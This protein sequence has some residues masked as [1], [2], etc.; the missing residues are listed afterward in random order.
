MF[1]LAT[2]GNKIGITTKNITALPNVPQQMNGPRK[3]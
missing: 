3:N 2:T 1:L